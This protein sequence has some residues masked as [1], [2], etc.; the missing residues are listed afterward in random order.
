[1]VVAWS[2]VSVPLVVL[3]RC[4]DMGSLPPISV[5]PRDGHGV[6]LPF[7][8]HVYLLTF[9]AWDTF[10]PPLRSTCVIRTVVGVLLLQDPDDWIEPAASTA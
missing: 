1:M 2:T 6:S 5:C 8:R 9:L 4:S 3:M 10:F 7:Y